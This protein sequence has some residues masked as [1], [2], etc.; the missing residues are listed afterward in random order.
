MGNCV[1]YVPVL[2]GAAVCEIPLLLHIA[3]RCMQC[4]ACPLA[5]ECSFIML[6][7]SSSIIVTKIQYVLMH[8]SGLTNLQEVAAADAGDVT[9][10]VTKDT[11]SCLQRLVRIGAPRQRTKICAHP[12]QHKGKMS[13][14]ASACMRENASAA[15]HQ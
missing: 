5:C 3:G 11:V 14:T 7:K 6:Q 8:A 15:V 12:L 1:L 13:G 4:K 10:D 2:A 9:G